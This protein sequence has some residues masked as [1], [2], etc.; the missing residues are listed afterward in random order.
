M[1]KQNKANHAKRVW[2]LKEIR[3]QKAKAGTF[4]VF[5]VIGV[6]RMEYVFIIAVRQKPSARGVKMIGVART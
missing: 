6:A 2:K 5:F 4:V 1:Y 3:M